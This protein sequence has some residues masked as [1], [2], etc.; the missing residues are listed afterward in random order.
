MKIAIDFGWPAVDKKALEAERIAREQFVADSIANEQRIA[1][2][3]VARE[4]AEAE[5]IVREKAE[6]ERIAAEKA[7]AEKA[8]AERIAAEKAFKQHVEAFT[9]HFDV[10]GAALNI[11]EAEKAVVDELC[12]KIKADHSINI[13]IT[14]HTD[15]IGDPRQNLEYYG[16]RRAEALRDY[17]V[18][19]GVDAGQIK[20]D[21]KGQTE[22]VAPNDT[23]ANRAL[24][25]RANIKFL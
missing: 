17:M 14:G 15:N 18:R 21:S 6:A 2:E 1:A 4:K 10:E 24:N 23:R 19:Q 7:A 5:R 22:P 12:E 8:E 25:R 13:L 20:C 3:K 11:P 16:M 9:V